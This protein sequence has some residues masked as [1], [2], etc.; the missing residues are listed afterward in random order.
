MEN[1][2]I[3]LMIDVSDFQAERANELMFDYIR[4]TRQHHRRTGADTSI[5][6]FLIARA[7]DAGRASPST[8]E[9]VKRSNR[10]ERVVKR[11]IAWLEEAGFIIVN[12]RRDGTTEYLIPAAVRW[13]QRAA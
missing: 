10:S 11:A 5:Y 9:L 3:D 1:L 8:D 6:W 12:R 2:M 7:D 4:D 13:Q